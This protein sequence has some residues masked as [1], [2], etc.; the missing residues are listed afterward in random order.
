[1][2]T[3]FTGV[4]GAGKTAAG[5]AL[6]RELV[7]GGRPLFVIELPEE[8]VKPIALKLP[9]TL[10]GADDAKR[11]H[12]IVPD[13]CVVYMPEAQR[14]WPTRPPSQRVPEHVEALGQHRHRTIEIVIDTQGPKL[15]D[16]KVRQRVGRHVH[17]RD[18]GVLGRWWYEWPEVGDITRFKSAL[19]QKRYRLPKSVFDLYTSA[20]GHVKPVRSFPKALAVA[21]I[22]GVAAV[23][24]A[25]H[26]GLG[27]AKRLS[28]DAPAPVSAAASTPRPGGVV[29]KPAAVHAPVPMRTARQVQA[30][31]APVVPGDPGS[32]LAYADLRRVV[33]VPRI[34][35]GFCGPAGCRCYLQ[36]GILAPIPAD[37]CA[38]W[39]A[40]PPFDPYHLPEVAAPAPVDRPPAS[41]VATGPGLSG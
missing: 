29:D 38:R 39:V 19:V 40:R 11:W 26:F 21:V 17:L 6:V 9:H 35:G 41:V 24:L 20:S 31:F 12:E 36:G 37:V 1:M 5:V 32:A 16:D 30:A 3:L 28:G 2:L 18:L 10:I 15:I 25:V 13:D 23:G 8:N 27:M 34:Q 14:L 4:P 7:K 33:R 22:A